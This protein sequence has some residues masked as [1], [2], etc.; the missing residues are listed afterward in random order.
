M[1]RRLTLAPSAP[2]LPSSPLSPTE[3]WQQEAGSAGHSCFYLSISE[4][5]MM[6][7]NLPRLP[8]VLTLQEFPSLLA[9]PSVLDRLA[10]QQNLLDQR[11]PGGPSEELEE[12]SPIWCLIQSINRFVLVMVPLVRQ[13]L[14]LLGFL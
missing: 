7:I 14:V 9:C 10:L 5:D 3:P 12:G 13:V 11:L 6:F 8:L 1:L 4:H 2:A